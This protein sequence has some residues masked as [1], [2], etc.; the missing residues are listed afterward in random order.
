MKKI[1]LF[2]LV[3]TLMTVQPVL[4]LQIAN[5]AS[6]NCSNVGGHLVIERRGDGGEYGI[7]YF[8]DNKACE[9]WALFRG[10]CPKG[11]VKSTGFDSVDK[12]Y[13]VWMGGKVK[14]GAKSVCTFK[15]GLKCSTLALYNGSCLQ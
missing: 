3:V 6:V 2:I 9:E 11:G 1:V 5:P 14:L 15:G 10:E 8:E 4:A 12:K 13:C 7:C